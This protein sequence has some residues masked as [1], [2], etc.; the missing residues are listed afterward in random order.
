M[1]VMLVPV[2]EPPLEQ[3]APGRGSGQA[4]ALHLH[5][6]R[7]GAQVHVGIGRVEADLRRNALAEHGHRVRELRLT[8]VQLRPG[9]G[10]LH[11]VR[12]PA[13]V[14]PQLREP[15]PVEPCFLA[16]EVARE[17]AAALEEVEVPLEARLAREG[18]VIWRPPDAA[19]RGEVDHRV[20]LVSLL[21][22][23]R[24]V[25][26]TRHRGLRTVGV[27]LD[28][29]EQHLAAV[30]PEPRPKIGGH[31]RVGLDRHRAARRG[32]IPPV[33][34]E[35]EDRDIQVA[36][37]GAPRRGVVLEDE[38]PAPGAH[39]GDRDLDGA[40]PS[41]RLAALP[42]REAV[43]PASEG[44]DGH[45]PVGHLDADDVEFLPGAATRAAR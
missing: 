27:E 18:E 36:H 31:R 43:A 22:P 30:D 23:M 15:V 10:H 21:G 5:R 44:L 28:A 8:P 45:P 34:D 6:V 29:V 38:L 9:V 35:L 33:A 12:D 37:H 20:D 16:V 2:P 42:L 40:L 14:P 4:E 25:D 41:G 7:E 17:L 11:P 3:I 32:R 39:V 26:H 13:H 1:A 19:L 24:D